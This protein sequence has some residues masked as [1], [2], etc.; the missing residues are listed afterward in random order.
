[1]SNSYR[2]EGHNRSKG[3]LIHMEA[4]SPP[5]PKRDPHRAGPH[6]DTCKGFPCSLYT[7]EFARCG[8]D[9]L[10]V[11]GDYGF[12]HVRCPY[13]SRTPSQF[14]DGHSC[15]VDSLVVAVDGAC[16]D[17]GSH[18]AT[19]SA[20]GVY[21]G[22]DNPENVAVRIHEIPGTVHTNQ[23]AEL[24]AAIVAIEASVEFIFHGGQWQ[25]TCECN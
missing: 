10:E 1:M 9:N 21:F 7:S 20:C 6:G 8:V 15:H 22:P 24:V 25:C 17:N 14:F 19:K 4:G 18:I 23:R 5:K 13:A 12:M 3:E 2:T 16:P 11:L